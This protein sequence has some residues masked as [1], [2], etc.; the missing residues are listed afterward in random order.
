M[1]RNDRSCGS[2]RQDSQL[3][4]GS[5]PRI[6]AL[7]SD[8]CVVGVRKLSRT[9]HLP[10]ITPTS[11]TY[12][13]LPRLRTYY[14]SIWKLSGSFPPCKI[15][16]GFRDILGFRTNRAVSGAE[17]APGI[18]HMDFIL[19]IFYS[20]TPEAFYAYRYCKQAESPEECLTGT[21]QILT[22]KVRLVCCGCA[23]VVSDCP[24]TPESTR[25]S[26]TS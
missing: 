19:Y 5:I 12:R 18:T 16:A 23:D 6:G 25:K 15:A 11:Y 10:L 4:C 22:P 17:A 8:F 9:V 21:L 24:F 14:T 7:P 13:K 3:M 2:Q 26:Y 1:H 20:D